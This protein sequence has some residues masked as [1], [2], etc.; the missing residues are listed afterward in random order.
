LLAQLSAL[1]VRV[2]EY[3]LICNELGRAPNFTELCMFSALWS[4]HCSYKHSKYLLKTL[5]TEG[6]QVVCGPGENAGIID[7]GHGLHVSFK[8]ESHNHPTYV[9]PFQ[10]AAT[11]VGGILRDIITM[12]ARPVASLNA[13]RFGMIEPEPTTST[14]QAKANKRRLAGAVAGIAHYGN[15]MG[16][17]TV[18]GDT[19]FHPSY[20]GNPLVNAMSI[21][22]MQPTGMMA[23][24]AKGAGNPVLYV[25]SPTGRD[26]M[27][28]ASFASKALDDNKKQARPAVQTGDPYAEKVMMEAC[29]EAFASG[30]I[31]AAQDMGAAGL[32]CATAEMASKGNVGMRV[33]LD[34]VPAREAGMQ[35]WE[36]LSSESQERM[37]MVLNKGQE[38]PILEIFK[39]WR[40]PAVIIGEVLADERII[41]THH[42]E[43]VV[44]LPSKLLTDGAPNYIPFENPQE[45]TEAKERRLQPSHQ[46]LPAL[47][48]DNVPSV[49]NRMLHHSNIVSRRPI[50]QQ[51]D[52]HVRNNTLLTG[53]HHSAGLIQ[54]RTADNTPTP[55]ALACS[56]EGNPLHVALNPFVGTQGVVAHAVRNVTC[57]GAKP[58]AS[59]NNLNFGNPEQEAVAYELKTSVA[60]MREA[61]LAL[62]VPVTGGNV[63]LYNTNG[64]KA[65]Q[66]S[67]TVGIVGVLA[68][69]TKVTTPAFKAAGHAIALLGRFAPSLGGSVYQGLLS[70]GQHWGEPPSICLS[71]E[72]TLVNLLSDALLPQQLLASC[73]DVALG[74][75]LTTLVGCRLMAK[76]TTTSEPLSFSVNLSSLASRVEPA[77]VA[78]LFFGETH[79]CYVVSYNVAHTE[80]IQAILAEHDA[81]SLWHPLGH[82]TTENRLSV[83]LGEDILSIEVPSELP[84]L[85]L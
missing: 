45:A 48:V 20:D 21:G 56:L 19:F 61:C 16:I 38:A 72:A 3:T 55:I 47:T 64:T 15:C 71:T 60:G 32:T 57:V 83:Q 25:G 85:P 27:G 41:I 28:G 36:Y 33:E 44:D 54:L 49:L 63:S 77:D 26:G 65:I 51:Y 58:L 31:V 18:A 78:N 7:V 39:R 2:N 23:A 59:T 75:L 68:D 69:K 46:G 9:E 53:D 6:P 29:L 4:E 50:F 40:V 81:L 10:G 1:N 62:N 5:P 52:R 70:Q 67:P 35:A 42:G 76:N 66:P 73:Q 13:L 84:A 24:G 11:G 14:E 82:V 34:L 80:R 22:I 17:P 8:V 30:L 12:N 37:L 79:G 43:T 74:G